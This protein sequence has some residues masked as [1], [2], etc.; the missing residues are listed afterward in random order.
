MKFPPFIPSRLA[1]ILLALAL[2]ACGINAKGLTVQEAWTRPALEGNNAA[3]YFVIRNSSGGDDRLLGAS[4][5]IA[6]AAE[7]HE[8]GLVQAGDELNEMI[9]GGYGEQMQ[10]G[11]VMQ[12]VLL[13]SLSIPRGENVNFEPGGLH[14]M[15]VDLAQRLQAGDSF[16]LKLGFEK[17]GDLAVLVQVEER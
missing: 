14:V 12:M 17:A 10:T 11:E 4:A 5:E 16:T 9:A 1:L 3:V 2:G 13:D 15:L 8:S 6:R 7:I